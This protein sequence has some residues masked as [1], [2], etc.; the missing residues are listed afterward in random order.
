LRQA[1]THP[2]REIPGRRAHGGTGAGM[3][4]LLKWLFYLVIIG[5]IGLTIYAYLGDIIPEPRPMS[6]EIRLDRG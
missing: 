5:L 3:I 1:L 2:G 6:Q 4:R